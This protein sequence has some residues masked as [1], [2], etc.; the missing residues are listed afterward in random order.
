MA[1]LTESG[2]GEGRRVRVVP[3]PK[4]FTVHPHREAPLGDPMPL[5]LVTFG[6]SAFAIGAILAGW[7]ADPR[8]QLALAIPLIAALGGVAQF[9]AGM[10]SFARGQTLSGTFFGTFGAFW[11][12]F[13]MYQLTAV[14]TNAAVVVGDG[15]ATTALGPFG[16]TLG[17][18]C[19]VAL[20]VGIGSLSWNIWLSLT[21]FIAAAALF[22]LAW[23]SF[24]QGNTLLEAIAGWVAILSGVAA[25]VAAARLCI[26]DRAGGYLLRVARLPRPA[27][28]T[29]DG[30]SDSDWSHPY[31]GDKGGGH[32]L[33]GFRR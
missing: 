24:A 3:G 17:C 29:H 31:K 5:G 33:R 18:L 21:S 22:C 9:V 7:W 13:G 1:G 12:G 10:W 32:R 30:A 14:R 8:A 4:I 6:T 16:V 11:G 15:I 19:F 20:I 23:A 25:F 2:V 28:T 26:G 27:S